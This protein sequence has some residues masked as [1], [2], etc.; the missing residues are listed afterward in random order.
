MSHQRHPGFRRLWQAVGA[1]GSVRTERS[2][3]VGSLGRGLVAVGAIHMKVGVPAI[4]HEIGVP[5]QLDRV[6]FGLI[7]A[8]DASR[9]TGS[10]AP[11]CPFH[12]INH[13]DSWGWS[14][15]PAPVR[16]T[17]SERGTP[18]LLAV[19]AAAVLWGCVPW[20]GTGSEVS[21]RQAGGTGVLAAPRTLSTGGLRKAAR[22]ISFSFVRAGR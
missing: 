2:A 6:R 11:V 3:V 15:T 9:V 18:V 19:P 12:G 8:S 21:A 16:R 10:A 14:V 17:Y 5:C 20:G 7:R 4:V 1:R 22:M 13:E